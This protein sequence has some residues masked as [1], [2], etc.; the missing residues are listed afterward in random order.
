MDNHFFIVLA[1]LVLIYFLWMDLALYYKLQSGY[2]DLLVVQAYEALNETSTSNAPV[3]NGEAYYDPSKPIS[4][5]L[6]M[7]DHLNHYIYYPACWWLD[8]HLLHIS[9]RLLFIS[10]DMISLT[11]VAV[12]AV[13]ARCLV[14][15]SLPQRRIGV[16]LFELRSMLDSYDGMVARARSNTRGMA[17]VGGSWGYW[18]DGICDAVGTCLFFAG[19]WVL[20]QKRHIV[21]ARRKKTPS[22]ST[23]ASASKDLEMMNSVS[24]SA[25]TD[26][27]LF[28]VE[29][30]TSPFLSTCEMPSGPLLSPSGTDKG[31]STS[32]SGSGSVA[33]GTLTLQS[34]SSSPTSPP[35]PLI[36]IHHQPGL[37]ATYLRMAS[38]TVAALLAQQFFSSLFWNR[39]MSGFHE[40]LEVPRASPTAK[41]FQ[42]TALKSSPLWIICWSWKLINPHAQMSLLLCFVFFDCAGSVFLWIRYLGF[43]PVMAVAAMSEVHMQT[44]LWN[45]AATL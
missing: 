40:L 35:L 34:S 14:S 3:G 30:E 45:S 25:S 21:M 43:L 7:V 23:L 19:A 17:Q 20:L 9:D 41:D 38:V 1:S 33:P 18:M 31:V 4:V 2:K 12:A 8:T 27:L 11:H 37:A 36:T 42:V 6:L 28:S 32:A 5:K 24:R 22:A 10:P 44:I 26:N 39:Y 29:E 15:D 16:I 13:G